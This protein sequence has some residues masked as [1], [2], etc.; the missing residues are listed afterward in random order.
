MRTNQ[1]LG[2]AKNLQ[3]KLAHHLATY[4]QLRRRY[5]VIV[6]NLARIGESQEQKENNIKTKHEN[7]A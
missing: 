2:N 3:R 1:K 6:K 5:E 7:Y 4:D